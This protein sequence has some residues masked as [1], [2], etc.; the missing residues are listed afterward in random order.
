MAENQYTSE[1]S[2]N[3][4]DPLATILAYMSAK[5][6]GIARLEQKLEKV[7]THFSGELDFLKTEVINLSEG[8]KEYRVDLTKLQ[9]SMKAV[10]KDMAYNVEV[11]GKIEKK[12]S[13]IDNTSKKTWR[14][15]L[16]WSRAM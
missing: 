5:L 4:S 7:T 12:L 16:D 10:S 3:T 13:R 15:L 1:Y 11:Q 9:S 2:E 6:E 14:E 8:R